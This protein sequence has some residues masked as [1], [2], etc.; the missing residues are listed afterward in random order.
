[1]SDKV[2]APP[3]DAHNKC[4]VILFSGSEISSPPPQ[5]YTVTS[6]PPSTAVRS[7]EENHFPELTQHR[8][9]PTRDFDN[10]QHTSIDDPQ[11]DHTV[12]LKL[13]EGTHYKLVL[14]MQQ[15]RPENITIKL[16]D[17]RQLTVTAHDEQGHRE[18]FV[19]RHV[20]P[21]GVDLDQLTSS[22]SADGI[23]VIKAPKIKKK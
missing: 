8:V 7:P 19:Q 16:N 11:V 9:R 13:K 12:L 5:L 18:T 10:R 2:I 17:S 6:P 1:M 3:F 4:C 20:V 21:K 14:N 22:F 15:Y 23:L